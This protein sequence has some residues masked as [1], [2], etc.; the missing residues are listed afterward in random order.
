VPEDL[1][2]KAAELAAKDHVSI[3]EF[4]PSAHADQLTTRQHLD[5]RARRDQFLKALAN[6][7][8]I[9]P[10]PYDRL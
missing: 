7:P 3:Q 4:A 6:V 10:E 1:Y 2:A 9:N 8:D 5:R